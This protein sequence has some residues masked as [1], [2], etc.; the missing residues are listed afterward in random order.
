MKEKSWKTKLT[1]RKLWLTVANLAT[2]IILNVTGSQEMATQVT[3][4]IMAA[5]GVIAYVFA[6]AWCD[7]KGE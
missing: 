5:G 1:S 3:T 4:I 7:T 2:M 6:Q